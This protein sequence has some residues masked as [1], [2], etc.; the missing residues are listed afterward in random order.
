MR[1]FIPNYH[2]Y[3]TDSFPGR[4]CIPRN[5]ADLRYMCDTY[6]WQRRSLFI[7]DKPILSSERVLH[8][9]Y[10]H[11]GSAE[12]NS[13]RDPQGTWRQDELFRGKPPV[14]N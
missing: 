12:K 13:G 3:L 5:R 8:K 6:T 2:F 14:V 4:K 7:T 11:K 10:D 1:F 9:D